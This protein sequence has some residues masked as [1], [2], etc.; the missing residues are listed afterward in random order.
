MIRGIGGFS[1]KSTDPRATLRWGG[2]PRGYPQVCSHMA[3]QAWDGDMR[4]RWICEYTRQVPARS[5]SRSPVNSAGYTEKSFTAPGPRT[6]L[7]PRGCCAKLS[8]KL[9]TPW[10]CCDLLMQQ[11]I[12]VNLL[13]GDTLCIS[14]A[15][16]KPWLLYLFVSSPNL[17][18]YFSSDT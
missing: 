6:A 12:M 4:A 16:L 5:I 13:S 11:Q 8:I 18:Q 3:R 17:Y 2:K 15:M 1:F 9:Y 7:R 10:P 14:F